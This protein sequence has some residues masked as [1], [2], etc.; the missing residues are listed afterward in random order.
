[1]IAQHM[2]ADIVVPVVAST[3]YLR[4]CVKLAY[5]CQPIE[6]LPPDVLAETTSYFQPSNWVMSVKNN[7]SDFHAVEFV[8]ALAGAAYDYSSAREKYRPAAGSETV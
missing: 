3:K 8:V 1:M 7:Q 6:I 4:N 5:F 2:T